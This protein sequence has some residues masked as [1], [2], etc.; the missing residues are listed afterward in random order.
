MSAVPPA[1]ADRPGLGLRPAAWIAASSLLVM[2]VLSPIAFF[3]IFPRLVVRGDAARTVANIASHQGLFLAGI[4][5]YVVTFL[6][7]IVV[8]WALSSFLRPVH[9]P[10]SRLAAWLRVA[11]A[12]AA[13][14]TSLRL[15]TV[16]RLARSPESFPA[17]GRDALAAQ[18]QL[19]LASFRYEWSACLLVFAAHLGVLAALALRSGYVPRLVGV[20]LAINAVAYLVDTLH[21]YLFPTVAMPWLP[22]LFFGEIVF[23]VWLFAWGTRLREPARA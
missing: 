5:C 2:S 15:V 10:L 23:M 19:L 21:P 3:A 8:A 18:V 11:Y 9:A 20:L 12:T 1:P 16:L 4:G 7:D 13:L 14:A 6:A 22:A 17:L